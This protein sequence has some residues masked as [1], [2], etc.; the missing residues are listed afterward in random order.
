MLS[1]SILQ[2]KRKKRIAA[3]VAQRTGQVIGRA[4]TG[5]SAGSASPALLD[6]SVVE[7][8]PTQCGMVV[9]D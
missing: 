2:T 4:W 8:V 3:S 5:A 9:D 1:V 6:Q 7:G